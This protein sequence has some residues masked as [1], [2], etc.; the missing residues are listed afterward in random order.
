MRGTTLLI[1]LHRSSNR[2]LVNAQV[3]PLPNPHRNHPAQFG[4]EFM[5][6]LISN[7]SALVFS[8]HQLSVAVYPSPLLPIITFVF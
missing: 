4:E 3:A 6:D 7:N 1:T 5:G 8:K 2:L